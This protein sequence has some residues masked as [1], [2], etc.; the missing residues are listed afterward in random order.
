MEYPLTFNSLT[1]HITH[2]KNNP[3]FYKSA[4]NEI[5]EDEAK[6][7]ESILRQK[8]NEKLTQEEENLKKNLKLKLENE[9]KLHQEKLKHLEEETKVKYTTQLLESQSKIAI[10]EEKLKRQNE[11]LEDTKSIEELIKKKTGDVSIYKGKLDE[12]YIETCIKETVSQNFIVENTGKINQMDIIVRHKVSPFRIGIECKDKKE[13]TKT[14]MTKFN[15]DK[16][17]NKFDRSVF[18][19]NCEI[20]GILTCEN[21]VKTI[22]DETYIYTKDQ[23][24]LR[25]VIQ[26]YFSSLDL[27]Q[28]KCDSTDILFDNIIDLYNSWQESKKALLKL[29]KSFMKSLKLVDNFEPKGHLYIQPKSNIKPNKLY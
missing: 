22:K 27:N 5:W 1:E 14:D 16:T 17:T 9:A 15:R 21:T 23:L 26:H 12:K 29:D 11:I 2:I 18:I 25:A 10:M 28:K 13:L 19:S 4:L 7:M 20:K 8:I 3:E 6:N 24:F